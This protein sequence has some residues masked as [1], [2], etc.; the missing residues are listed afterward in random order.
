M[1]LSYDSPEMIYVMQYCYKYYPEYDYD[2]VTGESYPVTPLAVDIFI[3][4]YDTILSSLPK[5]FTQ[6]RFDAFEQMQ[7]YLQEIKLTAVE[8]YADRKEATSRLQGSPITLD[9]QAL[10]SQALFGF[11]VFLYYTVNRLFEEDTQIAYT[12]AIDEINQF[13]TDNINN[14]LKIKLT[15][16]RK[17]KEVTDPLLLKALFAVFNCKD[18]YYDDL[19]FEEQATYQGKTITTCTTL[20]NGSPF[21]ARPLSATER[22]KS[23]LI[24]KI[25]MEEVLQWDISRNKYAPAKTAVCLCL[26]HFCGFLLGDPTDVCD[27]NNAITL[28]RL[29]TDFKNIPSSIPDSAFFYIFYNA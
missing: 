25:I 11:L 13:I 14:N 22:K 27:P 15:S 6:N 29:F 19:P 3:K 10:K 4:R 28:I 2:E 23:Y 9:R 16:G 24:I 18:K 8:R 7:E 17:S 1:S 20:G 5:Q 26:L 12:D 21:I